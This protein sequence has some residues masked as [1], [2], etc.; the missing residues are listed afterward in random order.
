MPWED[1][2]QLPGSRQ[3]GLGRR[4]LDRYP[5]WQF[6]AHPEWVEPH[7]TKENR[8]SAYAA[9]IQGVVWVIFFPA[10]TSWVAWRG[11][12]TIRGLG[13]G[14]EYRAFY[15]DPKPGQQHDL[16]RVAGDAQGD[17][18]LPKPPVFQDW[19]VVLET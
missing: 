4:L 7:Q 9:G 1:A 19:I 18:L 8:M 6:Q 13:E 15:W 11:E 2:C 17:W 16:G 10:A 12:L 5:W 3:L 14:L